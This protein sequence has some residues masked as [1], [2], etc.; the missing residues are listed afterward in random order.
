MRQLFRKTLFQQVLRL[1]LITMTIPVLLLGYISF[2]QSKQ[3]IEQVTAI[4][5]QDNLEQNARRIN[6]FVEGIEEHSNQIIASQSIQQLMKQPP[7]STF[8]EEVEF[9]NEIR[10]AVEELGSSH[11][12]RIFPKHKDKFANYM[13]TVQYT[14]FDLEDSLFEKAYQLNGK[15]LWLHLL[16][17]DTSTRDLIYMRALR[18]LTNF[19]EV[20][21]IVIRIPGFLINEM[22]VS[23]S[24]YPNYAVIIKDADDRVLSPPAAIE[25]ENH[26]VASMPINIASWNITAMIPTA[27]LTGH[28]NNIKKVTLWT[29]FI[30]LLV[31]SISL[32]VII[33]RFTSPIRKIVVHLK[34]IQRGDLKPFLH[35]RQR[36][37]EIGQLTHGLNAMT[38]AL[39]DMI[40]STK[41]IEGEKR[42]LEISMLI[43]QINPHFL[44]NTLD[45]IK[46][47]SAAVK[48]KD[49]SEMIHS[50]ANMLRYSLDDGEEYATFERELQHVKNY[51]NIELLRN[52][53]DFKVIFDIEPQILNLKV[54]KLV[55]QPIVENA[56]KHGINRNKNKNKRIIISVYKERAHMVMVVK[57]NGPGTSESNRQ[58][59]SGMGLK[60]VHRRLQLNFGPEYGVEAGNDTEVGY[61]SVIRHPILE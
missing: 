34:K 46:W 41:S 19:E 5:L 4:F 14:Q 39:L 11:D 55:L 48:D 8:F 33:G 25:E 35:Y 1:S 15:G 56:V 59:G 10:N 53:S 20:G 27:D 52:N 22:L 31:I 54:I 13:N 57:D 47:K 7:P 44:Y 40:E 61:K 58:E 12:T 42:R 28:I 16:N 23:P 17:E 50:L 49:I 51:L 26:F 21:V 6:Q 43:H 37:D 9:L 3:Q 45:S 24:Q 29:V 2:N 36:Q 32:S 60:N 30:S 18:T 38:S